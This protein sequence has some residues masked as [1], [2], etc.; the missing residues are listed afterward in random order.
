LLTLGGVWN[1]DVVPASRGELVPLVLGFLMLLVSAIGVVRWYR[2]DRLALA[3]VIAAVVAVCIGMAG[4]VAPDA[5][6]WLVA[7][8]PGVGLFR[9]G[10]RYLGPLVL[11][12]AV[13]FGAAVAGLLRVVPLKWVVGATAALV[14][15]AALPGLAFGAGL[16]VAQYPADWAQARRVLATDDRPGDFIPWP[17]ESYRA[18]SWNYKR[19]VLDPMP[20]YFSQPSI[21][22][23]E[24][25]VDGHRLAG[26]DP[27]ATAVATALREA[28]K[29]GADPTAVLLQQGVAWLVVDREAGGPSPR[30]LIPQLTEVFNGPT[31]SVY[32]LPGTPAEQEDRPWTVVLVLSAWAIGGAVLLAAASRVIVRL[33]PARSSL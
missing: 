14:P 3:L 6:E 23:D 1:A 22:P 12:E 33:R 2:Q 5:F 26:E 17:F 25:I 10:Q 8:V 32:R 27:R 30:E 7:N 31:V 20:R 28:M 9:D 24:L 11:V 13:G 29:T 21:V 15:I 16:K 19:P 4:V 18:P